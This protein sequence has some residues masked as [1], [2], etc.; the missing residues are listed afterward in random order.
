MRIEPTGVPRAFDDHAP[1]YDTLV[2]RNPGY[3]EHLRRSAER[4]RP[5]GPRLLDLGCGTGASTAAL[6]AA[7]PDAEIT[8]VDGSAEMLAVARGKRWPDRV[9][10]V[11]SRLEE[12]EEQGPFDG[13]LA[14][15]LVRN[16]AD[17][18]G[19]LRA[20]H[21]LLA[22]GAPVAVHEY[23]VADSL[24]ARAVWTAVSW[25]VIIPM[26]RRATGSADLYRYLWRSVLDF[27]GAAA[28]SARMRSAGFADA[29]VE[30]MTGW[31]R[32][33]VHTFLGR[34]VDP[35]GPGSSSG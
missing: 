28:L 29:R 15:Y 1:S 11:H 6:L 16:L 22:P 8:A 34:R 24:R 9:R 14:A 20:I 30:P 17:R 7:H 18:D 33:I 31:Q 35:G 26:G 27:D 32:G 23:S 3:H 12:L 4:L 21:D 13:I 10:F 5:T 19:G 2:G 25:G